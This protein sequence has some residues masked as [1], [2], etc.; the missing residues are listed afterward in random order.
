MGVGLEEGMGF[1]LCDHLWFF[2]CFLFFGGFFWRGGWG[3]GG[4]VN[5]NSIYLKAAQDHNLFL[6]LVNS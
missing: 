4:E 5:G 1:S 6:Y 2:S 3:G